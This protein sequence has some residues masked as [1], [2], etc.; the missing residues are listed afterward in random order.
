MAG[1]HIF[2]LK[3]TSQT[4]TSAY[5]DPSRELK[6]VAISNSGN[7]EDALILQVTDNGPTTGYRSLSDSI[8]VPS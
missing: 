3:Y 8:L 7:I 4:V 6:A 5:V 2:V 1:A